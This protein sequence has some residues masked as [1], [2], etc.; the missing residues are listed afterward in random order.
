MSQNVGL[1]T[2]LLRCRRVR[3]VLGDWACP[4]VHA[5]PWSGF[6]RHPLPPFFVRS[7]VAPRFNRPVMMQA[8]SMRELGGVVTW[9]GVTV[10]TC[11]GQP[12]GTLKCRCRLLARRAVPSLHRLVIGHSLSASSGLR[13]SWRLSHSC[14]SSGI[15]GSPRVCRCLLLTD[16]SAQARCAVGSI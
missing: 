12:P 9:G 15:G 2:P 3:S 4:W 5:G 14:C 7:F 8:C 6:R 13:R 16:H 10:N 11:E 1:R